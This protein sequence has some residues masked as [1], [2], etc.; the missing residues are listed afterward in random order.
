MGGA[1]ITF[2]LYANGIHISH[3]DPAFVTDRELEARMRAAFDAGQDALNICDPLLELVDVAVD[4]GWVVDA[5]STP[6]DGKPV[7]AQK[8]LAHRA[9]TRR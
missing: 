3:G 2:T 5:R 7:S 9:R 4:C 8:A 6:F 1:P